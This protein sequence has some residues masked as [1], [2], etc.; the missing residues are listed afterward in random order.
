MRGLAGGAGALKRAGGGEHCCS[1][2]RVRGACRGA[3]TQGRARCTSP[4]WSMQVRARYGCVGVCPVRARAPRARAR[5]RV[6]LWVSSGPAALAAVLWFGRRA[7]ARGSRGR[8]PRHAEPRRRGRAPRRGVLARLP[9]RRSRTRRCSRLGAGS[10]T[11]SV[12]ATWIEQGRLGGSRSC[13]RTQPV[14]SLGGRRAGRGPQLPVA[15]VADRGARPRVEG[16]CTAMDAPGARPRVEVRS[17]NTVGGEDRRQ[18]AGLGR[19]RAGQ[20]RRGSCGPRT[21]RPASRSSSLERDR[22]EDVVGRRQLDREV[23]ARPGA[24]AK[25]GLV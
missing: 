7:A 22:L 3:C 24:S 11:S 10:K 8:S 23:L 19:A 18:V 20:A 12:V 4:A 25:E 13:G 21:R 1:C 2:F 15:A 6:V 17:C 16:L 14:R 9:C 5:W